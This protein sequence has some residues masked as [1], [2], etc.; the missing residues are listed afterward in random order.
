V[1]ITDLRSNGGDPW[2]CRPA[3]RGRIHDRRQDRAGDGRADQAGRRA[4]QPGRCPTRPTRC[5]FD[6]GNGELVAT[7][8]LEHG[9]PAGVRSGARLRHEAAERTVGARAGGLARA[10]AR[11]MAVERDGEHDSDGEHE[12]DGDDDDH[13]DGNHDPRRPRPAATNHGSRHAPWYRRIGASFGEGPCGSRRPQGDDQP[14]R[15]RC[16]SPDF[17]ALVT[18]G[19]DVRARSTAAR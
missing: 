2:C 5:T 4:A 14:G 13:D 3:L 6:N 10:R 1:V 11:T 18:P 16:R 7:V 12:S 19:R 15:C 9:R 8:T 17:D